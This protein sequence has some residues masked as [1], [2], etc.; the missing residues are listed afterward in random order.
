MSKLPIFKQVKK[1]WGIMGIDEKEPKPTRNEFRKGLMKY[2]KYH[3]DNG[4]EDHVDY[5][6]EYGV[7][8]S[9]GSNCTNHLC[10]LVEESMG[11]PFGEIEPSY[12]T[13][14]LFFSTV[15]ESVS[16]DG[17]SRHCS[18]YYAMYDDEMEIA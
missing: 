2:G 9:F 12:P 14:T 18:T 7:W 3:K 5:T 1:P 17:K 6:V 15:V 8:G 11:F 13:N 16:E 10:F 4:Y